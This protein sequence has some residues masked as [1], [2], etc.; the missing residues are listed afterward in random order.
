MTKFTFLLPAYKTRYLDQMLKSIQNQTYKDYKVLISDDCSPED[1][2]SVC[3]PYLLDERFSYRRNEENMG[4]KSLVSHWNLLVDICDTEYLIM[5]SDDDVYEPTFLE[6]IDKLVNKYPD[7]DLL[8]ARA[9]II[10]EDEDIVRKD[11]CYQ[12]RTSQLEFMLQYEQPCHVTCVGNYVYKTS[13]LKSIDGFLDYPLAWKSDTMTANL[14][15]KN[16]VANT[17]N[18]LF[19]FRV[20]GINISSI[21]KMDVLIK[22]YQATK[23]KDK[24]MTCLLNELS[25]SQVDKYSIF[26]LSTISQKHIERTLSELAMFA[27]ALPLGDFRKAI[28]YFQKK[29]YFKSKFEIVI[30]YKKWWYYHSHNS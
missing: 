15:A 29:N 20:S 7:V 14:I 17:N 5:A 1:I 19:N 18:I 13:A 6:E 23:L 25:E 26:L 3:E 4:S 11:H 12:D 8:R 24:D 2:K 22:K 10:D 9:E 16:G 21:D 30:L 28:S 27:V